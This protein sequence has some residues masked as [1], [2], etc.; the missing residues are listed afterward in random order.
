MSCGDRRG[1]RGRQEDLCAG[2]P[3]VTPLMTGAS[4]VANGEAVGDGDFPSFLE[5]DETQAHPVPVESPGGEGCEVC[6]L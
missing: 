5:V 2:G 4:G 6:L 1:G 3:G